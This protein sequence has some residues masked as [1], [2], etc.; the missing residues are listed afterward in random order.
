M[1]KSP[2]NIACGMDAGDPA[3]MVQMV[4][5]AKNNRVHLPVEQQ[6]HT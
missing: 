3:I 1:P 4:E 6:R 5:V 2:A